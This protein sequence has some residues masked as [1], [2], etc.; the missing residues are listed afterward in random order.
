MDEVFL[1]FFCTFVKIKIKFL[2]TILF[3]NFI[4]DGLI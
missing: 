1:F 3:K 4:Q 2:C